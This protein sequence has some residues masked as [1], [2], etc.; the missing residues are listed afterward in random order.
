MAATSN[1][2]SKFDSVQQEMLG[3][4]GTSKQEIKRKC[5]P[6]ANRN[7]FQHIHKNDGR[8]IEKDTKQFNSDDFESMPLTQLEDIHVTVRTSSDETCV[9]ELSVEKENRIDVTRVKEQSLDQANG[10][11]T[12]DET[13]VKECSPEQENWIHFTRVNEPSLD[14]A[15][16]NSTA[17][18]LNSTERVVKT[19][20]SVST[21]V[22]DET[23]GGPHAMA[24]QPINAE[25]EERI[26][27]LEKDNK[28]L[29]ERMDD[30]N[31]NEKVLQ[32]KTDQIQL[33]HAE[34]DTNIKALEQKFEF[35]QLKV[36]MLE[37]ENQKLR[38]SM[39]FPTTVD[40]WLGISIQNIEKMVLNDK[41]VT[42]FSKALIPSHLGIT[43]EYFGFTG[44][45]VCHIKHDTKDS[46]R[47]FCRQ[48]LKTWCNK[49]G[50]TATIGAL[51]K[52]LY[53]IS[54]QEPT[55]IDIKSINEALKKANN[56]QIL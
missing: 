51:L 6:T 21:T 36:Q 13:K 10:N 24:I 35:L 23:F 28:L 32:F 40:E 20:I 4:I 33:A 15:N 34:H 26:R 12:S 29:K 9:K 19:N 46:A 1:G 49:K 31:R 54:Q 47:E 22:I 2:K 14:Q 16:V 30:S 38:Q 50:E 39:R 53:E 42:Y 18:C 45:E 7:S 37:N 8:D 43:G 27:V 52:T 55:C 5:I 25:L 11:S 17:Y 56:S 41:L 44:S 48:L 3:L